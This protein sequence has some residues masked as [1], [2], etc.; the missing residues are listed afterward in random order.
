M[1]ATNTLKD[2]GLKFAGPVLVAALVGVVPLAN[3]GDLNPPPGP[4]TPTMKT[5]TEVEPRTPVE[6]LS[7]DAD[8]LYV[9]DEPGSYYLTGNITGVSGKHGI[10][11]TT[12]GVTLDLNGF[13]LIGVPGS[14]AGV[15]VSGN[16]EGLTVRNGTVCEWETIGVAVSSDAS[17][18]GRLEDLLIA[19]SPEVT[20]DYGIAAY[21]FTVTRCVVRECF[22]RGFSVFD[23]TV[24]DCAAVDN[25]TVG[26][27]GGNSTITDC[28]ANNNG[29]GF[30][31]NSCTVT[32][33]IATE[34][35]NSGIWASSSTIAQCTVSGGSTGR[36]GIRPTGKCVVAWNAIDQIND[37]TAGHGI[38][39]EG[40]GN[41]IEG[42]NITNV[43]GSA[44]EVTGTGNLII[45]NSAYQE[46]YNIGPNN[47][48]GPIVA[49][50]G[51]MAGTD[52]WA[53]LQY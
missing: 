27:W 3:A 49:V 29:T 24:T 12:N 17:A 2:R 35:S 38:M 22:I 18:N 26:F 52:P 28:T 40:S 42:N 6:S 34:N 46:T 1:K 7:G 53:N 31:V 16:P 13:A 44:I 25:T 32:H 41:R 23:G 21:G 11:I 4:V 15:T 10:E 48:Y 39:V 33:C 43:V 30:E 37:G 51:D 9:I 19:G 47:A 14:F 36:Y 5:L 20:T 8:A 50:S 45:K